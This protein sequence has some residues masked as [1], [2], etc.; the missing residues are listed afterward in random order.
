MTNLVTLALQYLGGDTVAKLASSFGID[1]L[2]AEKAVNAAIPAL[3]G[4]LTSV[5]TKP[6]G[7]AKVLDA[8]KGVDPSVLAGLGKL[9]GEAK[10]DTLV[11]AGG[12]VLSSLLGGSSTSALAGAL[13]KFAGV[14]PTAATSLLG[15]LTPVVLGTIKNNAPGLDAAKLTSLLASQKGFIQDALPAGL[16]SALGGSGLL[17]AVTGATN[18]A[19]RAADNVVKAAPPAPKSSWTTWLIPLVALAALAQYFLGHK[20]EPK[21]AAP[22]T[23]TEAP[24]T[25]PAPAALTVDG[26][27]LTKSVSTTFDTLKS[28]LTGITD[29]AT[30]T[31]AVPK[32]NDAVTQLDTLSGLAAKLGIDQKKVLAGLIVA[33]M[34]TF[35]DLATK[36]LAIPGVG[37][38]AKP[39]IDSI[40]AKLDALSKA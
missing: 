15:L 23:T 1:S 3:L 16:A 26:V 36:V 28:V 35:N 8:I 4:A 2:I 40:R 11:N 19:Q 21:P 14:N 27:D 29:T 39:T 7:A 6:G 31:A 5:A 17:D 10:Q 32:L 13:G 9:I 38:I 30:A 33:A 18:A 37:D 34:P 12:S 25:A 20:E 24:A 22:A